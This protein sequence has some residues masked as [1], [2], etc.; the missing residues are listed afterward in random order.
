[1][2]TVFVFIVIGHIFSVILIAAYRHRDPRNS[3]VNWFYASRWLQAAA[4]GTLIFREI[5]PSIIN[6]PLVNSLLLAGSAFETIAV[7]KVQNAYSIKVRK[8][9]KF[10]IACSILGFN[11]IYIL[12]NQEN[13]RIIWGSIF[14]AS[15]L[16]Y[17][18]YRM[19]RGSA[20]SRLT[21]VMGSLYSIVLICLL[22]RILLTLRIHTSLSLFNQSLYQTLSYLNIYF[23]MLLGNMGFILLSKEEADQRITRWATYD[24]LTQV[25]NRRT[26][27]EQAE[28]SLQKLAAQRKPVAFILFDIDHFKMI[29]DT[30]GHSVGDEVLRILSSRCIQMLNSRG[31]ISRYGGDEFAILLPNMCDIE[32]RQFA[33]QFRNNVEATPFEDMP[34]HP[35]V[36]MGL[37]TTVATDSIHLNRL[38]HL[39]DI[40]LYEAKRKG[41]NQV[42]ENQL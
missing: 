24:D 12:H 3:A 36:S 8:L 4:W 20:N 34:V 22:V 33:E 40:A 18:A 14:L 21:R 29:N 30:Y 15:F 17:P 1:M 23:I 2:K 35:T 32:A 11:A 10:L 9:Y 38:Y 42:V 13:I 27:I 25:L 26:F 7:L 31:Y 37:V 28:K 41:R 16:A 19:L 6:I 39:S 5:L